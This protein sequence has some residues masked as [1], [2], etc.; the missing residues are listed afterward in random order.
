MNCKNNTKKAEFYQQ[1]KLLKNYITQLIRSGKKSYYQ[2]Y[3]TENKNN[4]Q[5]VWKGIKEIINIKSRNFDYPTCI[6][7]KDENFT[8]PLKICSSFNNYFTSVADEILKKRKYN[9]S[10]SYR[11]FL[12]NSLL[13]NFVFDPWTEDEIKNIISSINIKKSL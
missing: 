10:K 1:F 2:R 4:I 8:D 3:F 5:K 6:L 9:G 7:E 13:E 11:D 12:S